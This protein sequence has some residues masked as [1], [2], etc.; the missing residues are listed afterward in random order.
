MARRAV[1]TELSRE[2]ILGV[3]SE[4]FAT[5]GY[6]AVSMRSIAQA[7]GYSHG[8]L[9]YHFKE[10]AELFYALVVEDFRDLLRR[11][12]EIIEDPAYTGK[13]LLYKLMI[14]FIQFGVENKHQYE[15]MF[16]IQDP[17]LQRYSRSEQAQAFD[18]FARAI[19][20]VTGRSS[21]GERM[22]MLP[23]HLFMSL[24][25][26]IT[27]SNRYGQSYTEVRGLAED[28]VRF[29]LESLAAAEVE[30]PFS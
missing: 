7:L 19:G 27:Y 15:I 12:A 13:Q 21:K 20:D 14:E 8:S 6:E 2:R 11:Q 3:A 16:V 28:H 17:D 1:E 10:K 30:F 5:R 18:V 26:F 4:L 23:W 25:G 29:L 9:Y 22:Y 24:H